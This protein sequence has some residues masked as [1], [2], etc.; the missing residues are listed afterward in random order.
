MILWRGTRLAV[1]AALVAASVSP[2]AGPSR[3]D[4]EQALAAVRGMALDKTQTEAHRADAVLA[5]VRLLVWK[6]RHEEAAAL[7]REVLAGRGE[8]AVAEAA[9]WGGC[10]VERD[11]HGHLGAEREFLASFSK[12]LHASRAS[13]FARELDRSARAMASFAARAMIPS[14]V[15]TRVPGWAASAPG[16]SPDALRVSLPKIQP[17][18]WLGRVDLPRL[19][20]PKGK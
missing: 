10:L 3:Q 13:G 17:P 1:A 8:R 9:L 11:R 6:E 15:A 19:K 5:A 14:P 4:F 20:E 7:C 16:K 2:A 18:S 12:G